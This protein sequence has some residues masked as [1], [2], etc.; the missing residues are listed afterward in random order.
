M[1]RELCSLNFFAKAISK[2]TA[3]WA[4]EGFCLQRSFVVVALTLRKLNG[5]CW[6]WWGGGRGILLPWRWLEYSEEKKL[7]ET[8][9]LD[10]CRYKLDHY[11]GKRI[12]CQSSS[13]VN[14]GE[15]SCQRWCYVYFWRSGFHM[16]IQNYHTWLWAKIKDANT[17]VLQN[18]W[19]VKIFKT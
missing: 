5:I 19:E 14:G 7:L 3:R 16:K 13:V 4:R 12:W 6:S 1:G 2:N 11:N 8:S 9:N 15:M 10:D 17:F 18:I